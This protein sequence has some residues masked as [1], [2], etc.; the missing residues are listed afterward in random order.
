MG[1]GWAL[2]EDFGVGAGDFVDFF[3]VARVVGLDGVGVDDFS[4]FWSIIVLD[5]FKTLNISC[6]NSST[7]SNPME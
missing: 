3:I 7:P 5:A 2:G 6:Q 1:M 4:S